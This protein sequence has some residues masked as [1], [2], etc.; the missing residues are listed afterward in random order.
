MACKFCEKTRAVV[1]SVPAVVRRGALSL[2]DL[3]RLKRDQTGSK[4]RH[5]PPPPVD[6]QPVDRYSQAGHD[7]VLE[8][9]DP[10][11]PPTP[12]EILSDIVRHRDE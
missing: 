8:G 1:S 11:A 2:A 4:Q 3:V 5:G 6:G 9:R 12:E 7:E 10:W